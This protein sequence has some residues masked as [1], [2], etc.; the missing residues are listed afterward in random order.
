[1]RMPATREAQCND[2]VETKN[3]KPRRLDLLPESFTAN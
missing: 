1:M 2:N 3:P